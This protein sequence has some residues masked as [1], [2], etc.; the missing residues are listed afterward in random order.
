MGF[1][2]KNRV[3]DSAGTSIVVP[4]GTSQNR[5]DA[6]KFGSFRFNSDIGKMEFFNGSLFRTV[7][8]DGETS[9]TVDS[10]VG[11]GSTQTFALSVSA[12][13]QSQIMVFVGSIYQP[14]GVAYTITGAGNDIT[15]V[16]A[17]PD[18]EP[19]NVVHGLGNT[20]VE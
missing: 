9:L 4:S 14:P 15:F 12:S 19:I 17:V 16:E 11:D 3:L 10:F 18:N 7:S 13:N 6:P 5:P 2:A 8:V 1:F 20:V